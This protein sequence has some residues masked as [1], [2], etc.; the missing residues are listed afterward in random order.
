LI[1]QQV[2]RFFILFNTNTTLIDR[3]IDLSVLPVEILLPLVL[4][5]V[6]RS[7]VFP[8]S[9]VYVSITKLVII[10]FI[11]QYLCDIFVITKSEVTISEVTNN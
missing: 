7:S 3:P 1:K 5:S 8:M 10:L 4:P 9:F 6:R 11:P 2:T